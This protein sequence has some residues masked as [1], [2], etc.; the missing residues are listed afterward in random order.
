MPNEQLPSDP[1]AIAADI[2][3][4]LR[5]HPD[6]WTTGTCARDAQGDIVASD[7]DE[8]VCWC[9]M[10]HI[11]KRIPNVD[12]YKFGTP[13]FAAVGLN[14]D[15][16]DVGFSDLNDGKTVEQIIDLCEKVANG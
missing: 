16:D 9:L 15:D 6:H 13:F 12:A 14:W 2:A 7:D 8:A 10:G 1:K 3:K 4:E 11:L 5:E